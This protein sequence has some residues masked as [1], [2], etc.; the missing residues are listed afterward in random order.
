LENLGALGRRKSQS[1]M[2]MPIQPQSILLVEDDENDVILI[3]RALS[4]SRL[5]NPVQVVEDGDEAI[6]YLSG[7]GKYIDRDLYPFP[8]LLLLDLKLPRKS[9]FEVIEIVRKHPEWKRLLVVVLTSS[10]L[11]PD[12]NRAYEL[13]ANSYLVKPPDFDNL[14]GMM[15][16]LQSYW[17]ICNTRG[18]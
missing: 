2:E 5:M 15:K 9:G 8:A 18:A 11:H 17:L 10:A 6:T 13:G 3:K 14:I 7:A 16:E 12:I 4:K 1:I